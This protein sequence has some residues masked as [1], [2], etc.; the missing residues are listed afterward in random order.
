MSVLVLV[1]WLANSD[2]VNQGTNRDARP[3]T[4]QPLDRGQVLCRQSVHTCVDK[5][6][7]KQEP[8]NENVQPTIR[9]PEEGRGAQDDAIQTRMHI[10]PLTP[11]GLIQGIAVGAFQ[12]VG[13]Q[14]NTRVGCRIPQ[15]GRV[16]RERAG[17]PCPS[18]NIHQRF[19]G[20]RLVI[21]PGDH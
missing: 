3:V 12:N 7:S 19:V 9:F 1:G 2:V 4:A 21:D 13:S 17:N 14:Q 6:V 16:H 5:S 15:G 18:D 10:D 20:H 8:F 11:L